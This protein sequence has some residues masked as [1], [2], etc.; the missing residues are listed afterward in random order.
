MAFAY[1]YIGVDTPM[2]GLKDRSKTIRQL[3]QI[4]SRAICITSVKR[5]RGWVV[6]DLAII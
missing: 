4:F 6:T 2:Y 3:P 1:T 5:S